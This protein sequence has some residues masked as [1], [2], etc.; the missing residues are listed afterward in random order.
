MGTLLI[1]IMLLVSAV[2]AVAILLFYAASKH[3]K[4]IEG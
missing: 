2:V 4:E 3:D 1:G